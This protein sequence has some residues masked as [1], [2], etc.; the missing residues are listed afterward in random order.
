MLEVE[1]PTANVNAQLLSGP[2]NDRQAVVF[3]GR[4]L[5]R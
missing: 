1:T 5:L 2:A 3:A 4:V